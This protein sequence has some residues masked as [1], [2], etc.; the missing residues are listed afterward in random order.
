MNQPFQIELIKPS[1]YDDQGYVIQWAKAWIPSNSLA[2]LNGLTRRLIDDGFFEGLLDG[3]VQLR[4]IDETHSAVPVDAICRRLGA[5]GARGLVCLVGVQSNQFPRALDLARRFRARGIQVAIGGFHVSGVIAMLPE[6]PPEIQ[7]ALA[8]GVSL[9]AGEAEGRLEAFYRD[10][11]AGQLKP[12]YDHLADLP[13]LRGAPPPWMPMETVRRYVGGVVSFDAGR[14]CPFTCS[15]C[16]IINVQGQRSRYRGADDVEA[17][18]RSNL[19]RGVTRF[20][21]T[22]DNF[23]R[24][25]NWEAIFDRL[26]VLVESTGLPVSI[27]IQVDTLCHR[28][29][30]FIEKAKRAGV[31]RVFIGL[32]NINPENLK[33]A[34]K[35]QNRVDEY[36]RM[37]LAWR[38]QQILTYAGYILGFPGD[39]PERIRQ[40]IQTIKRE[41]PI[42]V[43]EFFCLTPLP[44]SR[45][46]KDLVAA[47]APLADDLNTYDL[48][49]VCTDHPRMS[50][51]EWLGI[52]REAW[53]SFYDDEHVATL[54]RRALATGNKPERILSHALQFAGCIRYERLHPL[55]G[56][57][58][59]KKRRAQRRP[60]MP[61]EPAWRFY[62][63]RL[64]EVLSTNL[65]LLSY[66]FRLWRICRRVRAEADPHYSD[67][68]LAGPAEQALTQVS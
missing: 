38:E 3:P 17:L 13:S 34:S 62:P 50:R 57:Y 60:T 46:H 24:N 22:D 68:A 7:A 9:F 51:S 58:L 32:E 64:W 36:R 47:G 23:A 48:E 5:P 43:L 37:L 26:A 1:H 35:R 18:V 16:T 45:D 11:V 44:G 2:V 52:Y 27:I 28:I 19:E 56:G 10:A 12:M 49:H 4:A 54:M 25:R 65:G 63:K 14:G 41:L 29:P 55:Q 67:A 6:H 53:D 59:R 30:R 42:D 8:L 20:F 33:A 39:T 21:I 31:A 66:A 15:F 61:M 40:D